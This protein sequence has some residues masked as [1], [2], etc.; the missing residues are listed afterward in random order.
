MLENMTHDGLLVGELAR[1]AGTTRKALRLYEAEGLLPPARRT[2][3]GYRVYSREAL[4]LLAFILKARRIGFSVAEIKSIVWI[5]RSGQAPC[6]HV[7]ELVRRKAADVERTLVELSEVRKTLRGLLRSWPSLPRGPAAVC[8]HIESFNG[9]KSMREVRNGA[10]RK[11][12]P[13]SRLH[14]MPR[15]RD[16]RRRGPNRRRG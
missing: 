6:R 14:G 8:R 16:R 5:R 9:S 3:S 12:V 13:L 15:S 11:D 7:H 1:E 2:S 4:P 10:E